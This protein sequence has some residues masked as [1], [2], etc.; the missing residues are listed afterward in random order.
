MSNYT[1]ATVSKCQKIKH[2]F[3]H[4]LLN[5]I[6]KPIVVTMDISKYSKIR[7]AVSNNISRFDDVLESVFEVQIL[8]VRNQ[9]N[10]I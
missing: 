6:K 9:F 7:T 5:L 2:C 8:I 10:N 3:P 1:L 4:K